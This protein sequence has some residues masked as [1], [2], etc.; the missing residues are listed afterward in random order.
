[1]VAVEKGDDVG[2]RSGRDPG[3]AGLAVAAP[4]LGHHVGPL[5]PGHRGGA[6]AGAV[7]HHDDLRN[8]RRDLGQ[9]LADGRFFVDRFLAAERVAELRFLPVR[10]VDFLV[11]AIWFLDKRLTGVQTHPAGWR[12]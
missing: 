11:A 6:V 8:E 10:L 12:P 7:V 4:R 1:V 5:R 3:E 2:P 9:D